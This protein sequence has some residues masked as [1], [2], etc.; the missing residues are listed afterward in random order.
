MQERLMKEKNAYEETKLKLNQL[1]KKIRK[2]KKQ[3]KLEKL[4]DKKIDFILSRDF[5]K[6]TN[7]FAR[8]SVHWEPKK[9]CLVTE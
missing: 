1:R 8:K 5:Q 9:Q 7:S 2:I 3:N 4:T 6:W